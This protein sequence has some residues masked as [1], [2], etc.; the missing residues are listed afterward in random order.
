MTETIN[1][2]SLQLKFLQS[3]DDTAGRLDMFEM[4]AERACLFLTTTTVG[5]KRSTG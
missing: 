3:N 4:T 2:G 1:L 5:M